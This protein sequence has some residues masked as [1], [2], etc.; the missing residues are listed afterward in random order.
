MPAAY[1]SFL[2]GKY[3]KRLGV[4]FKLGRRQ[5]AYKRP[6]AP[7]ALRQSVRL[8][9][10]HV[11]HGCGRVQVARSDFRSRLHP[12]LQRRLQRSGIRL[13]LS[14]VVTAAYTVST[15]SSRSCEGST[16]QPSCSAVCSGHSSHTYYSRTIFIAGGSNPGGTQRTKPCQPASKTPRQPGLKNHRLPRPRGQSRRMLLMP[17]LRPPRRRQIRQAVLQRPMLSQRL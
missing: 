5:A 14:A 16:K 8:S 15:A 6:H 12:L 2:C 7:V 10:K 17:R 13:C 4:L 3:L 1:R 11:P 9:P